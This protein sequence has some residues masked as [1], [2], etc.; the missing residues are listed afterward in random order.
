MPDREAMENRESQRGLT[1]VK[2]YRVRQACFTEGG[3]CDGKGEIHGIDGT[4]DQYK[5]TLCRSRKAEETRQLPGTEDHRDGDE[6][7]SQREFP[8]R[9]G[10]GDLVQRDQNGRRQTDREH[11]RGQPTGVRFGQDVTGSEEDPY[12]KDRDE[13]LKGNRHSDERTGRV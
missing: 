7:G 13:N 5:P 9:G 1:K 6:T 8:S 3:K 4:G 12:D 2:K 10:K 11:K